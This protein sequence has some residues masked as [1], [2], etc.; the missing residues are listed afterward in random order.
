MVKNRQQPSFIAV[1][2]LLYRQALLTCSA[3][4]L[5]VHYR[6]IVTERTFFKRANNR[7]QATVRGM[8]S[9]AIQPLTHCAPERTVLSRKL[10]E[11]LRN[12]HLGK[13]TSAH[14]ISTGCLSKPA[15]PE[16]QKPI[17]KSTEP[18]PVSD[19]LVGF[20]ISY[21]N[22]PRGESFPLTVGRWP[23]NQLSGHTVD[24]Q[25]NHG[26]PEL[27]D[28]HAVIRVHK[29]SK[30]ELIHG[31]SAQRVAH[32]KQG[33]KRSRRIDSARRRELKHGDRLFLGKREF[34]ICI[35]Q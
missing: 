4:Q 6:C 16:K 17:R 11:Q 9:H 24:W 33:N 12:H 14:P 1:R 10:L 25:L 34:H 15:P 20:L 19:R 29:N 35:I 31:F 27:H 3:V 7:H 23:L 32:L 8:V 26:T 21:D 22:D 30:I 28:C 13:V 2:G 5:P 18:S